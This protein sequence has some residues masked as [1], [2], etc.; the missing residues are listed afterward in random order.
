MAPGISIRDMRAADRSV[1][2][3]FMAALNDKEVALSPD[4][5]PGHEMAEG[6]VAFLLKEVD[7]RGGFTLIA[8]VDEKAAA[9]LLAY[10]NSVDEG[11]IHLLEP[12]RRAGE[13][14]DIFVDPAYRRL[15]LARALIEEAERRF[16][17]MGLVRMEI[18]FLES[19]EAAENTYRAAGFGEHER[20]FT[21]LI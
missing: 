12:F 8:E 6:H 13:V 10:V 14:S 16:R 20:I 4:R 21:K 7:R 11:D 1:L 18:R 5:A 19:N 2:V 15:G 9:F 17:S 3:R